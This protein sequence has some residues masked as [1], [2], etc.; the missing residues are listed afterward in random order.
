MQKTNN[1]FQTID[2][3]TAEYAMK[4]E[5]YR[6][7]AIRLHDG[8]MYGKY[9]YPFHLAEVEQVL[10]SH[11]YTE[12]KYRAAAWLH[13]ALEDTNCT[14]GGLRARFGIEVAQMVHGC[15]GRGETRKIRNQ[16]IYLALKATPIGAPVKVADRI[17][18]MRQGISSGGNKQLKK[19]VKEWGEFA[20]NVGPLMTSNSRDQMLWDTLVKTV[21]HAAVVLA[22]FKLAA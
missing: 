7:T 5:D 11:D 1:C 4:V 21:A 20:E 10:V 17:A 9:P 3:R 8:Q 19:Y 2:K 16:A 22:N 13:D 6:V 18:N 15:T 12:Y 14:Y